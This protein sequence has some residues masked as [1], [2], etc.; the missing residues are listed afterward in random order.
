[1]NIVISE[2]AYGDLGKIGDWI[3]RDNPERALTFTG[4]LIDRCGEL[5]PHPERFVEVRRYSGLSLRKRAY[6]G[7]LIFYWIQPEQIEVHRIVHGSRDWA[8]LF[9]ENE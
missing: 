2:A 3:A 6:K 8:S 5:L 1:V 4:E 9:D 7:Y